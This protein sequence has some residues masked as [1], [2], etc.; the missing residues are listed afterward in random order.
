MFRFYNDEYTSDYYFTKTTIEHK[1][2]WLE[3][4]SNFSFLAMKGIEMLSYGGDIV[5]SFEWLPYVAM[6]ANF[7]IGSITDWYYYVQDQID[8]YESIEGEAYAFQFV[9]TYRTHDLLHGNTLTPIV[10][11]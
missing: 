6:A 11:P 10:Y 4:E 1:L 5:S 2:S 9:K 3:V 8:Y 7:V